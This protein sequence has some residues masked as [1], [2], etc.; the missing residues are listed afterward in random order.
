MFEEFGSI[1]EE[2]AVSFGG[3]MAILGPIVKG[4]IQSVRRN[5]EKLERE[6]KEHDKDNSERYRTI[7]SKFEQILTE[8]H[9]LQREV[10]LLNHNVL[11]GKK[12]KEK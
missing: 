5:F 9:N 3:L 4:Y 12:G 7:Y 1:K 10:H 2:L 6:I 11:N 8:I